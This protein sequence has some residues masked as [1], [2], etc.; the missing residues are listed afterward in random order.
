THSVSDRH[1][2]LNICPRRV[3]TWE[4]RLW[5]STRV[6]WRMEMFAGL[7]VA[8]MDPAVTIALAELSPPQ[9]FRTAAAGVTNIADACITA[10]H[11]RVAALLERQAE[12]LNNRAASVPSLFT[13]L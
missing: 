10:G 13:A 6:A 12:Y 1:S 9:R 2:N 8:L 3:P 7:S 5:N 11:P 4:F